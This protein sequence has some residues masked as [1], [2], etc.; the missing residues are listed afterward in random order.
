[1][2]PYLIQIKPLNKYKSTDYAYVVV[3]VCKQREYFLKQKKLIRLV[4]DVY[5]L[6]SIPSMPMRQTAMVNQRNDK[7]GTHGARPPS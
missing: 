2:S 7:R 3:E 1:M 5:L 6:N 4:D